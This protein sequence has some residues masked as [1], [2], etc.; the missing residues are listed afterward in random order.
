V[1]NPPTRTRSRIA[2]W[3]LCACCALAAAAP[4]A[5]AASLQPGK[6][7][8]ELTSGQNEGSTTPTRQTA[9]A[10]TSS[11]TSTSHT[12]IFVALGAAVLLLSGIGFVIARDARRIAPATEA[13]VIAARSGNDPRVRM[14][15]RRAK[16]KAARRQRKRNR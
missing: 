6:S 15:K 13:D 1:A 14:R 3:L 7:F 5:S 10:S 12:L 2:L 8:S 16:A 9:P 11:G 4:A